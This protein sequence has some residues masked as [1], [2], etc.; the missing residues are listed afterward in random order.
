MFGNILVAALAASS[1]ALGGIMDAFSLVT[2]IIMDFDAFMN[3]QPSVIGAAIEG[4]IEWFN[5]IPDK[6][7]SIFSNAASWLYNAGQSIIQ[8]LADGIW[9]AAGR[10]TSAISGVLESVRAYLPFSPAK[11]GPFSGKGWTLYSGQS[12]VESLADGISSKAGFAQDAMDSAMRGIAARTKDAAAFAVPPSFAGAA[13][14]AYGSTTNN[15][16]INGMQVS[17]ADRSLSFEQA[18]KK[19]VRLSVANDGR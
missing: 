7:Q 1:Y 18:V 13:A 16:Y 2:D 15:Y 14:G 3:G 12:I 5:S 9:A 6:I 8:G 19:Y 11:V 10:A 17:D 4:V